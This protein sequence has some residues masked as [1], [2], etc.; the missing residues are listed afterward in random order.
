MNRVPNTPSTG[1][2]IYVFEESA[3]IQQSLKNI[4]Q[5][6]YESLYMA[7][8]MCV[9]HKHKIEIVWITRGIV[10]EASNFFLH[11]GMFNLCKYDNI[12]RIAWGLS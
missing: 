2:P 11:S 9:Y 5:M 6:C 4:L 8:Y 3:G 10:K 7:L 12:H 1:W